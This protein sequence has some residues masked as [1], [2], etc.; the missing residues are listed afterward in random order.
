MNKLKNGSKNTRKKC[1]QRK[2]LTEL[3]ENHNIEIETI[4]IRCLFLFSDTNC[5]PIVISRKKKKKNPLSQCVCQ[6]K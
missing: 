6:R 2:K 3:L 1:E 4:K 5:T